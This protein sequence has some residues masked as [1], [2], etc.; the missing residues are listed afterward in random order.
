M[1]IEKK[2]SIG[3]VKF[4]LNY[5]LINSQRIRIN[6]IKKIFNYLNNTNINFLD[7]ASSYGTSEKIIGKIKNKKFNIIS[8]IYIKNLDFNIEKFL[9]KSL[10]NLKT[11]KIYGI[12][13]HNPD[14][15]LKNNSMKIYKQLY[16][17]KKKK[18]VNKIGISVY[19]PNVL[20]KILKK[21]KF[22]IIQFPANVFDHSFLKKEKLKYYKTLGIELHARSIFLQG[23]LLSNKIPNQISYN[24]KIFKKY[25]DYLKK[26]NL[27]SLDFCLNFILQFKEIDK[28]I[29]GVDSLND[30]EQIMK[31]KKIS[32]KLLLKKNF[33]IKNKNLTDPRRW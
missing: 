1:N 16:I 4:G 20:D 15:F 29:V 18:L 5:G 13:V 9:K 30:L 11:K 19:D 6:E 10:N 22:D 17:L 24:G 28:V 26:N 32:K 7:T 3:T 14:I 21:F 25:H 8:K 23:V 33:I 2:I 27:K 12:L 31:Y